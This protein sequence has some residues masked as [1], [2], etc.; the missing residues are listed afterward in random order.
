MEGFDEVSCDQYLGVSPVIGGG[1]QFVMRTVKCLVEPVVFQQRFLIDSLTFFC[2]H[3][4]QPTVRS[5][6]V[7]PPC[8]GSLMPS[9]SLSY[10]SL[11]P[12]LFI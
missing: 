1:P 8:H 4:L 6:Q 12:P 11:L 10:H 9:H 2:H 3:A 5:S 7:C